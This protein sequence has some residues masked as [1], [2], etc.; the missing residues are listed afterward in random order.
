MDC[1]VINS[2]IKNAIKSVRA[3]SAIGMRVQ[4]ELV[5]A[6][7]LEKKDRSPVT[8]A[9]FAVQA[10]ISARLAAAF[11]DIPLVGEED[12]SELHGSPLL[13]SV[14]RYAQS[15][16][17]AL[18]SEAAVCDA[19]DRGNHS[20][21]VQGRF[22]TLDPIDG[23][24]GFLRGGQYAIALGLIEDGKV[25]AGVLSCPNLAGG[26][27][28]YATSNDPSRSELIDGV[29]NGAG[30]IEALDPSKAP[31]RFCESVEAG[32]SDQDWSKGIAERLEI[33]AAPYRIDSQCKYA[34][35]ASGDAAVYLRLPTQA[36]Y[37][38]KIWDHAA[39]SYIL[40]RAGGTVTDI[41][42]KALDFSHGRN[43]KTNE[44]V[45]A[46]NGPRHADVLSAVQNARA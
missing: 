28:Y 38:E 31:W 3:A 24:K 15:V 14:C 27:L 5:S 23:T 44:G 41:H 2:A 20:G 10:V 17:P 21:G 4:S 18:D 36:G 13:A 42:G 8:V 30:A 19:I 22:W 45:I 6:D 33:T 32:H 16:H 11:P 26:R 1:E 46:T 25:V 40:E 9:D 12:S 37:E 35:V 43:L 7:R 39:G 29:E 34:A